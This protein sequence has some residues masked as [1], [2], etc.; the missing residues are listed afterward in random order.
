MMH[1]L[2][3]RK[4]R[5]RNS[6]WAVAFA[7]LTACT[8]AAA[9]STFTGTARSIDGDSLYVGDTEVRL[10]GIDAPEFK[11]SCTRNG[12]PWSCGA[13]AADQLSK[14]VT[15][16]QVRCVEMDTDEHGRTVARC[17]VGNVDVNRAMVTSG[18]AVAY[19][20]YSFAYVSA[21]Q[22]AKAHSRGLWSGKFRMPDEFRH[23]QE[24]QV[25]TPRL[26]RGTSKPVVMRAVSSKPQPSGDCRIKGNRGGHGR[27]YHVPGQQYYN[28]TVAEQIF[29][30]EGEA[31]A[32]GYRRSKV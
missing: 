6:L 32:A 1:W 30:T 23:E 15:G 5:P 29:C 24:Y 31:R 14:L 16:K 18:Y 3:T 10:F 17:S 7:A 19:R 2:T 25:E 21:E 13:A 11:Q 28:R 12:Q 20:R 8:P 27:I 4:M 26:G 9:Q 22:A